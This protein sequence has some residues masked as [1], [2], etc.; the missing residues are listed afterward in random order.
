V[1]E[2]ELF[3]HAHLEGGVG[4]EEQ[5]T[6]LLAI[7]EKSAPHHGLSRR[8][9]GRH[10]QKQKATAVAAPPTP[11]RHCLSVINKQMTQ[12]KQCLLNKK[13]ASE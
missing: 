1:A 13:R 11:D 4:S 6:R 5:K 2:A 9:T 12:I 7:F 10:S 8:H 3:T